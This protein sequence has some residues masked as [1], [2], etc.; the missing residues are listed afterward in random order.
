MKA[1]HVWSV[2]CQDSTL[3]QDDNIISLNKVLEELSISLAPAPESKGNH[4]PNK[5]NL[6]LNYEIVSMW[7]KD[8]KEE[9]VTGEVEYILV[10]PKGEEL[11]KTI[12][13][14]QIPANIRRFRSRMKIS[15]M[16]L[17]QAGDYSFQVKIKEEG[18]K[19]FRSVAILPLEVK[20]SLEK[21]QSPHKP[22]GEKN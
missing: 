7:F 17:T 8:K 22:Q 11:L 9:V 14:I 18:E 10:S 5:I 6:P 13:N 15:G 12:Q 4:L 2:L 3:N 1:Q 20:I 16:P 21:P 19:N